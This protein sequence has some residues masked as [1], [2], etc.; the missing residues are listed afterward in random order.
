MLKPTTLEKRGP[1]PEVLQPG[2]PS[3]QPDYDS[4]LRS[5]D[6]QIDTI[7]KCDLGGVDRLRLDLIVEPNGSVRSVST[8]WLPTKTTWCVRKAILKMKFGRSGGKPAR[9]VTSVFLAS[10]A[11]SN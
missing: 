10:G 8:T 2:D 7:N 5:L 6:S 1:A 9:L 11:V 3:T 4:L